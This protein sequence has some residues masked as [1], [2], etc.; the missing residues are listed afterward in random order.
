[1]CLGLLVPTCPLSPSTKPWNAM[2]PPKLLMT[3]MPMTWSNPAGSSRK[4]VHVL[5]MTLHLLR[6]VSVTLQMPTLS[7]SRTGRNCATTFLFQPP[8]EMEYVPYDVA[9]VSARDASVAAPELTPAVPVDD[10]DDA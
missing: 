5:E 3:R 10:E 9:A 1:M 2:K 4:H 6:N 8:P 7:F